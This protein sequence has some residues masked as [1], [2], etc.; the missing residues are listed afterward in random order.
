MSEKPGIEIRLAAAGDI[1]A[2]ARLHASSFDEP[3]DEKALAELL[4]MPGAF[5]LAVSRRRLGPPLQTLGFLL[6]REAAGE[7][8][9]LTVAVAPEAR[10]QGLGRLLIEAAAARFL[11][12]GTGAIFLEV[13]ADNAAALALYGK[14]GFRTVGLRPGYYPRGASRVDARILRL[15]LAHT[16][17][18]P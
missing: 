11:A 12:A 7:A 16:P 4:A 10:G 14:L 15:D 9:I 1:P 8:E 13:A 2:F 3:W 5:A 18:K 17:E 6:C